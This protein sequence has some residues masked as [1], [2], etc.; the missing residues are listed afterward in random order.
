[1][2]HRSSVTICSNSYGKDKLI[3]KQLFENKCEIWVFNCVKLRIQ[4][5]SER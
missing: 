1:M 5:S 3:C 2:M 4:L